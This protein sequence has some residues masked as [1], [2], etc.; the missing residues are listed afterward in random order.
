MHSG[1]TRQE[2]MG[3]LIERS[4]RTYDVF[5]PQARVS[6]VI[7]DGTPH[8]QMDTPS[9]GMVLD[10]ESKHAN[11]QLGDSL[12]IPRDYY[13]KMA[14]E[15]P[16]L[17]H[18]N[19]D[20]WLHHDERKL[21]LV[22]TI[23]GK[24]EGEK[25]H[26]RA[27]LSNSYEIRDSIEL[28]RHTMPIMSEQGLELRNCNVSEDFFFMKMTSAK[29]TRELPKVGDPV[30]MG[31]QCRTSEVGKGATVI[32]RFIE[33]LICTNGMVREKCFS[34]AHLGAAKEEGDASAYYSDET[35]EK[36][37]AAFWGAYEDTMRGMMTDEAW[38]I[39]FAKLAGTVTEP[40][41][42]P[43]AAVEAVKVRFQLTDEEKD[44]VLIEFLGKGDSTQWQLSNAVTTVAG[45][46]DSYD[47]ST[48]L[49]RIG[50]QIIDMTGQGWDAVSNAKA[51]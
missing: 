43:I 13:R 3:S 5:A 1:M 4:N 48:Q 44:Q 46:L 16:L 41:H 37:T 51:A 30:R 49:E 15:K 12:G 36:Q 40:V 10:L 31:L 45:T 2:A 42:N 18:T 19:I 6:P 25:G 39:E 35:R 9:G 17:W 8:L 14:A 33:N 26:L 11:N 32:Q 23:T 21:K 20:T 27:W 50:G 38:E 34:K 24:E 47:R 28:L 7:V 22:R 29:Y